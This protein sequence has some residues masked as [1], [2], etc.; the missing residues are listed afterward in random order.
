MSRLLIM[1]ANDLRREYGETLWLIDGLS[2][3]LE[4]PGNECEGL[5]GH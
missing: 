1:C 5:A 3:S 2:A 4:L